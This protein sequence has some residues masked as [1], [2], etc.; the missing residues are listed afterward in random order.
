[1]ANWGRTVTKSAMVTIGNH[2]RTFK[3]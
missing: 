2:H 1:M 3:G